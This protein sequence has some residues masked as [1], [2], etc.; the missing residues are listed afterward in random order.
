[1]Y[2]LGGIFDDRR[3]G[4]MK[5]EEYVERIWYAVTDLKLEIWVEVVEVEVLFQ[6]AVEG[7]HECT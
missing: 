6:E 2:Y 5:Q 1:M 7:M 4:V 3:G